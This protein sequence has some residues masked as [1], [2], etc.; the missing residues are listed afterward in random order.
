MLQF[1]AMAMVMVYFYHLVQNTISGN[2]L[3]G[4]GTG[5]ATKPI[6]GTIPVYGYGYGYGLYLSASADIT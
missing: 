5:Y 4:N 3:T 1:T 6:A 2:L